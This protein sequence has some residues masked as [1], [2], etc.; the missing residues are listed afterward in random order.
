MEVEPPSA[1]SAP[2]EIVSPPAHDSSASH[3]PPSDPTADSGEDI[4]QV[5]RILK[6]RVRRGKSEFYIKWLGFPYRYN[7]WEPEEN[8]PDYHLI[9]AFRAQR[10][11]T[12]GS[13]EPV[14]LPQLSG[15]VACLGSSSRRQTFLASPRAPSSFSLLFFVLHWPFCRL[16]L[17]TVRH[18]ILPTRE[19]LFTLSL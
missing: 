12:T 16:T 19:F 10:A 11:S 9:E 14:Q 1:V 15:S 8:I 6:E 3:D 7:S 2:T 4:F 5:E 18:M 17:L 13:I